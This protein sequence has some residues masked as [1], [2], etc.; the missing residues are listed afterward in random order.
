VELLRRRVH[1]ALVYPEAAIRRGVSGTAHVDVSVDPSGVI[2]AVVLVRSSSHGVL[3]EAALDA[4]RR[5]RRVPFPA[6]V[7]P[8]AMLVRLPVRFELR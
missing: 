2:R 7:R 6:E 5:L 8:R 4:V 1:D 3:D